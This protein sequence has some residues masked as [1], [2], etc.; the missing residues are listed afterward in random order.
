M[1]E[2]VLPEADE[3]VPLGE[4]GRCRRQESPYSIQKRLYRRRKTPSL[5]RIRDI[6]RGEQDRWNR[7]RNRY[8]AGL[9]L[10]R[11]SSV[12]SLSRPV[13]RPQCGDG[14]SYLRYYVLVLIGKRA[15]VAW[16]RTNAPCWVA[17]AYVLRCVVTE[18]VDVGIPWWS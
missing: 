4:P 11:A 12:P 15:G 17:R 6:I 14:P 2:E 1:L 3:P 7:I 10:T 8:A 9:R 5:L 18:V 16:K 13:S